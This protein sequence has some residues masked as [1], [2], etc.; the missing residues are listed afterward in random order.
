MNRCSIIRQSEGKSLTSKNSTHSGF[1]FDKEKKFIV[2]V[3]MSASDYGRCAQQQAVA[4]VDAIV[5]EE[6]SGKFIV[7]VYMS[8]EEYSDF[9]QDQILPS[10]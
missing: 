8:P 9:V 2:N 10:R 7:P 3:T 4:D 6:Q 5:F 1:I